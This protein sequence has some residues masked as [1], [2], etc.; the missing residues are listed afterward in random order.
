M[1]IFLNLA[2]N[3]LF[4]KNY[5]FYYSSINGR[6]GFDIRPGYTGLMAQPAKT[7]KSKGKVSKSKQGLFD[8]VIDCGRRYGSVT[9]RELFSDLLQNSSEE[10]CLEVWRGED[11]RIIDTNDDEKEA[12]IALALLMFE[13]EINW[14]KNEWQKSSNFNPLGGHPVR[15][16]PRDM[17]MGYV[18]Q[19]FA[20]GIDKMKYWMKS[21]PGTIWF[22]D[23]DESRY[24]YQ[25]YPSIYKRYFTELEDMNGTEPVMAGEILVSFKKLAT[26]FPDN[27]FY[28][29]Y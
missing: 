5:S 15:R 2:E 6:F 18:R 19:A 8:I 10:K 4:M 14:G 24:G 16:R 26:T 29:V 21:T 22:Y 11:P 13:Q 20:V 17:I 23:K 12:L 7:G 3:L 25:T 28:Q 1:N 9:H 27:P